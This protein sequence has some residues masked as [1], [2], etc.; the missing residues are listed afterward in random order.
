[1]ANFWDREDMIP[2]STELILWSLKQMLGLADALDALYQLNLRHGDLNS[3]NIL[4]FSEGRIGNLVIAD[5]G[6]S[7]RHMHAPG[8][9]KIGITINPTT[10][11]YNALEILERYK[12]RSRKYDM[13]S[14]GCIFLDFAV[15]LLS[16]FKAINDFHD[17]IR[18][19]LSAGE[20]YIVTA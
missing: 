5:L 11:P 16:D 4:Y 9:R 1:M 7:H 10:Q 14:L 6:S 8:L 3:N 12:P 20:L 2:R 19:A 17:A 15:W 18:G 13:W